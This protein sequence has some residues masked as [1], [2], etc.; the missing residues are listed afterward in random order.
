MLLI[1]AASYI[2][3]LYAPNLETRLRSGNRQPVPPGKFR[4]LQTRTG[5]DCQ[6]IDSQLI[7]AGTIYYLLLIQ[8]TVY[9]TM[10]RIRMGFIYDEA[11]T[12]E[13]QLA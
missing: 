4:L 12:L 13:G 7:P 3:L 10:W 8:F 2:I 11:E 5:F 9:C 1:S 6:Y